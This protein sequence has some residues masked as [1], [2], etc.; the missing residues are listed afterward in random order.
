MGFQVAVAKAGQKDGEMQA[1]ENLLRYLDGKSVKFSSVPVALL[2][3]EA[4]HSY[5]L[6]GFE[7]HAANFLLANLQPTSV[8]KVLGSAFPH[9]SL[10]NKKVLTGSN[11]HKS[12]NANQ[13]GA[14][15]HQGRD[16]RLPFELDALGLEAEENEA[17]AEQELFDQIAQRCLHLI[18]EHTEAVFQTEEWETIPLTLMTL[19]L[20]RDTLKVSSELH[21]LAALDRYSNKHLNI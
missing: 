4:A 1:L 7:R 3:L 14:L 10:F 5:H 19:I 2:A 15:C 8:L 11:G 16:L 21:V 20:R 17:N 12:L 13:K 9:S 6:L 18:D